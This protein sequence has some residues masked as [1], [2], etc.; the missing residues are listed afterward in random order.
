MRFVLAALMWLLTTAALA[1]ALPVMWLQHNIVDADG[2]AALA[3]RAASDP[4]LQQAV[5]GEL[6]SQIGNL[7]SADVSTAV[8]GAL[9]SSYTGG[10]SF[11]GQFAQANRLAHR[12]MFTNSVQSQLDSQGRWVVDL[13]PMLADSSFQQTLNS[14]RIQV[15]QT[16]PVP[17]T[18]NV[19]AAVRP[20][21]LQRVAT[22]GPWVSA[23]LAGLAGLGAL[24]TVAAARKRGK[25]IAA[26]GVS[27]LLVGAVGWVGLEIGSS[28]LDGALGSVSGN[29]RQIAESMV[30]QSIS[31]MHQWLNLGLAGGGALVVLG[32]VV[33]LLGGI[34]HRSVREPRLTP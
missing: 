1:L 16:L 4:A 20:G 32:V 19:P 25:A 28:Y 23:G 14:Y 13:A 24:L 7:A 34:G 6:T 18:E 11:P 27:L 31:S 8:V 3:Q 22:W 2:Y 17:L 33:A 29:P 21:Q 10:S 15:P 9:A 30:Q 12:W 5:A 26:L